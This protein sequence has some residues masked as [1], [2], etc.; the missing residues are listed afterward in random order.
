M[1][2]S[3]SGKTSTTDS[4]S[5]FSPQLMQLYRMAKPTLQTLSAQT[6]E[7]LKTGGVNAQI[8]S[9][10]ASV[11]AAR[12][13][14]SQSHQALKNQLAESGLANSSFGQEIL[15]NQQMEAG[16]QIASIPTTMTND[17]LAR[18]VPTVAGFGTNA[19][20]LAAQLNTARSYTPSFWDMFLQGVQADAGIGK[21][22]GAAAAGGG[23]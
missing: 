11:A 22:V 7:G 10:N 2:G 4:S 3:G 21:S 12:E 9:V 8:P 20:G 1:A 23:P 13:A 16:Q 14:Y 15:G 6:A 17:F 18:G 19:L 5:Q